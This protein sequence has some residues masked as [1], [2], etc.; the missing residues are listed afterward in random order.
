METDNF[1]YV[2]DTSYD[3]KMFCSFVKQGDIY[4]MEVSPKYVLIL[5]ELQSLDIGHIKGLILILFL[6]LH[7]MS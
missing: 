1:C 5:K 7:L 6:L 3:G 4:V 2:F